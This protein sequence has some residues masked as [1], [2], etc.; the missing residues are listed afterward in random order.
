MEKARRKK[1]IRPTSS[2]VKQAV[3]NILGDIRGSLFLDLY[4]GSGQVGL[5]AEERGAE[6]IFV[7]KNPK[8]AKEIKKKARGNV[9]ISDVLKFLMNFD[10]EADV[11]FADPPYNY[12]N[13]EKLI[14]LSLKVLKK[15]GIF[16][17]EHG[18]KM[19]FGAERKKVYGDTVLS[20]WRKEDD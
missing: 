4:A 7:E 8:L 15:G 17:L 13:Y 18:K 3:F 19:D 9:I 20:L 12:E 14:Q 1:E 11:I 5:M 16:I 2:L 6:V 10:R